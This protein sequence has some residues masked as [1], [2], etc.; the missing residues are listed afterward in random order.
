MSKASVVSAGLLLAIASALG[1]AAACGT[2]TANPHGTGDDGGFG[3][4]LPDG[5]SVVILPTGG[6]DGGGGPPAGCAGLQ[7]QIHSC[8]GGGSTTISGTVYDPAGNNP[9]YDVVVY[10][11][12][13]TPGPLKTG[14]SCDSCDSLYT[15]DPI[16]AAQTDATGKFVMKNAPDGTSIPLVIQ[17]GKW[18]RQITIPSVTACQ[19]NPQ[20]DKTQMR[21]PRSS[22]EG[23]LPNIAISTGGADSL[24][25]LLTRIGVDLATEYTDSA[26][27]TGHIHIFRGS[28]DAQAA[29]N[30]PSPPQLT[31]STPSS[32]TSLWDQTAHMMPYDIVLLS[33]EGE[34]TLS[35]NQQALVDYTTAG[36]RVFAS[37][38]HY[39][40][41]S[42]GPF[43]QASPPLATWTAGAN[44]ITDPP[45]P[46]VTYG[47]IVQA[48]PDGGVFEKGVA[49]H[50][51]L[52]TT[53]SL[54]NDELPIVDPKH[55]AD[56]GAANTLS[57]EWIK[58]DKNAIEPNLPNGPITPVPGTTEYFTFDTPLHPTA[59][60]D[61]GAPIYCGRVVY[62]DLHVGAASGD[63]LGVGGG[64]PIV[65]SAPGGCANNPLSAQEKALEFMLFDL[66]SCVT[67]DQG[68][69]AGPPVPAAK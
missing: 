62:S 27:G 46:D 30:I 11:P 19:D 66:S 60:D 12:N 51:W 61:A 8:T 10:V 31:A 64:Q 14:A 49:L 9:L 4:T 44:S 68:P 22:S 39:N 52:Q 6:G 42:A 65:S 50:T 38:F 35:P 33:C 69:S 15:G 13:S 7:C 16:A 63:Y 56:L 67:P 43:S 18:R 58:A 36:G 40:W 25:C 57:Q 54:V 5:G 23:D 29:G 28:P 3:G 21:L 53:S 55:N 34:E 32:K 47:D 59:F 1:A 26:T 2:S 41:F 17:I 20:T 45:A 24:E 48:L 37:H